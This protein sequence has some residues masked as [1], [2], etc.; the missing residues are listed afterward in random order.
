[1]DSEYEHEV[2][3]WR[4]ST[5]WEPRRA[6]ALQVGDVWFDPYGERFVFNE[7]IEVRTLSITP[8]ES[9]MVHVE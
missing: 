4:D 6:G 5:R 9:G 1:M 7:P 3:S 2:P 8:V